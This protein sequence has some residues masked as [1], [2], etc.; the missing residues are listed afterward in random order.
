M[1]FHYSRGSPLLLSSVKS[2]FWR[3]QAGCLVERPA[4]RLVLFCC[5]FSVDCGRFFFPEIT[6]LIQLVQPHPFQ[7]VGLSPAPPEKGGLAACPGFR[8]GRVTDSWQQEWSHPLG[9]KTDPFLPR[10]T[11]RGC[12]RLWGDTELTASIP[13]PSTH[14]VQLKSNLW[15]NTAVTAKD[16]QNPHEQRA[17]K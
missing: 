15:W 1:C 2:M 9:Y 12:P 16:C 3:G 10:A 6:A 14:S 17:N 5:A 13:S 11:L 7:I 8:Q 4:F